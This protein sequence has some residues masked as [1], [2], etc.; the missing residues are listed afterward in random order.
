MAQRTAGGAEYLNMT[1]GATASANAI[2]CSTILMS[3]TV[4]L[5]LRAK[6]RLI[7]EGTHPRVTSLTSGIDAVRQIGVTEINYARSSAG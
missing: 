2:S 6:H 4:F 7:V 5:A 3:V 1:T